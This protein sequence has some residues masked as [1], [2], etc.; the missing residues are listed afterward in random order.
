MW[1]LDSHD[2][3]HMSEFTSNWSL[4]LSSIVFVVL[5]L[6]TQTR[7]GCRIQ[8]CQEAQVV[9]EE[10]FPE[11]QSAPHEVLS[12]NQDVMERSPTVKRQLAGS[13]KMSFPTATQR[14]L[15]DWRSDE[16]SGDLDFLRLFPATL[17]SCGLIAFGFGI[18][19]HEYFIGSFDIVGRIL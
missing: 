16:T 12:S 9:H 3:A 10:F 5:V 6:F 2:L 18:F 17:T 7:Q 8:C 19:E 15:L 1:S 14:R 13:L 11:A 4:L